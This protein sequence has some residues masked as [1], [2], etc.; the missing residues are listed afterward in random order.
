MN[1]QTRS[2]AALRM[3]A[4]L[5]LLGSLP[6]FADETKE[7][8]R[9]DEYYTALFGDGLVKADDKHD[10]QWLRGYS[11]DLRFGYQAEQHWGYEVRAF[12]GKVRSKKVVP[13]TTQAPPPTTDPTGQFSTPEMV[14]YSTGNRSGIGGDAIYRFGSGSFRPYVLAGIGIA[15]SDRLPGADWIGPY[16]NLGLGLS[17]QLTEIA[18]RPL[19]IRAEVRYAYEDYRDEYT[20]ATKYDPSNYLDLHAFIGL[21]LALTRHV[22]APTPPAPEVVPPVQSAPAP[23]PESGT[24]SP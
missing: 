4:A 9:A 15:Y 18:E 7:V 23:A 17:A 6:A 2:F 1:K 21:E 24:P 3:T 10:P 22:P 11:G 20:G 13:A 12:Y 19:R 14:T 5:L 16:V 8:K